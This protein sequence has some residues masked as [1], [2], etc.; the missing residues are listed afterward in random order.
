MQRATFAAIGEGVYD[1]MPASDMMSSG[2]CS[3][4]SACW[5]D[6]EGMWVCSPCLR[7]FVDYG[8]RRPG[9]PSPEERLAEHI[10]EHIANRLSMLLAFHC[11]KHSRIE[12]PVLGADVPT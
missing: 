4:E 12:R 1:R 6:L 8:P 5:R 10:L 2:P 3:A 9:Y 7:R 11:R